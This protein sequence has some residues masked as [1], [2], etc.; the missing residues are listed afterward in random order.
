VLEGERNAYRDIAVFNA[1]AALTVAGTA[2]DLHAGIAQATGA[3][4]SGK[5][6]AVLERLILASNAP[7]AAE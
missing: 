5:A 4:D 6:K 3:I 7:R 2:R 1:A